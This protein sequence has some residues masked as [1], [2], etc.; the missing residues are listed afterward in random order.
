MLSNLAAKF[1]LTHISLALVGLMWVFPFLHYRHQYPLTTFYQE[2]WSALIG[3]AALLLL[4]GKDFWAAPR[5]PRIV[6]LPIGLLFVI[7]LQWLL[8]KAVYFEQAMLYTLYVLFAALLIILGG[9]LR[10]CYG[11]AHVAWV[12]SCF[13]LVGAELSAL[14]GVLQHFG[15]HTPLDR[16]V[17][18]KVSAGVFGN[19]AQP[20]HF[21]NYIALGLAS[22]GLLLQQRKWH[23]L[24]VLVLALPLLLVMTLSGSRS[25]WLYLIM[26]AVL[27]GGFAWRD[28]ALRPLLRYTLLLIAGFGLMHWLVQFPFMSGAATSIDTMKRLFGDDASGGIRL[29]LWREA[30]VMFTQSPWLGVGIGQFALHHFELL[31]ELGKTGV[32]GLYNNAHSIVFQ[33]AAETG[34]AGLIV[35][36]GTFGALLFGCYRRATFDPA[37]WWGYAA[38]GVLVIHSLLEY[39]LWYTYFVAV[40]AVLLG[41][42]DEEEYPLELRGIGRLAVAAILLLGTLTLWQLSTSYHRLERTLALRPSSNQDAAAIVG[43]REGLMAVH[44]GGLLKPYAELFMS[45]LMD[46]DANKLQDKLALNTR[47]FRFIPIGTVS[48]RQSLLLA[49]AGRLEEAKQV[50]RQALWS[51]PHDF[52]AARA[53]LERLAEKDPARFSPLLE[54]ALQKEGEPRS[55]IH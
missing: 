53:Q 51:Y 47:V 39:P 3:V 6:L 45:S 52:I 9:W 22:L 10:R 30:M 2:W 14:A 46:V 1:R 48:Y 31:P 44:S 54:F 50:M 26:F 33:L 11:L 38:L 35:L 12:L 13:L 23:P 28:A 49:Q 17:V 55:G 16:V 41:L 32:S 27:A 24:W 37:H 42:M 43:I 7:L 34:L 19:L 5:V 4:T 8:G 40:V 18:M 25:S 15:W 36:F 29:Y 21:A 20:N